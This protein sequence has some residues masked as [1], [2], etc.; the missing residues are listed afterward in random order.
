MQETLVSFLDQDY[1]WRRDRLP[2]TVFLGFPGGSAGKESPCGAGELG[3]IAGLGR[4]PGEGKC[5]PIPVFWP[6]EFHGLYSPWC[7]KE[8]HATFTL[9]LILISFSQSFP[10]WVSALPIC[11]DAIFYSLLYFQ[12]PTH[13]RGLEWKSRK[14]R[15]T[16]SNRKIWTWSTEWSRAKANRVLP[17]EHTG[18]SKHLLP[19]T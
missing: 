15:N 13:Y 4:S 6:G 5:Y 1:P 10:L 17:R 14:S 12:V 19:T 9:Q 8:S 7:H 11:L 3:S 18:H 2:T 16:W